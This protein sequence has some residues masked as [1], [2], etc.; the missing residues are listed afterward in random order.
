ML[1]GINPILTGPV[2]SALDA[3]GHS[4]AVVVVDAHFPAARVGARVIE[5]P[6]LGAAAVLAAV[7]TVIP[8]DDAPGLDLM[9]SASGERLAVQRELISAAGA[10]ESDV[11]ELDRYAF[12]AEAEA[13][14]LILR[15]G[16]TRSYGNAILRKGLV[17]G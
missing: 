5:L 11:R 1:Q 10:T 3:M 15:T 2:L 4:D 12:Y 7:A 17:T 9:T 6:T 14:F 13:A 8:L 16:E